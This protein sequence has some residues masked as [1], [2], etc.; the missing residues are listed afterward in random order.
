[1]VALP[2]PRPP[3]P[4]LRMIRVVFGG[5]PSSLAGILSA[6]PPPPMRRPGL[7]P[8]PK[9]A[10]LMHRSRRREARSSHTMAATNKGLARS[11]KSRT[12]GGATKGR[13]PSM[14]KEG[15][16]VWPTVR[17]AHYRRSR[18]MR[19][20]L[21]PLAIAALLI[22][23]LTSAAVAMDIM[24]GDKGR[25]HG[26]LPSGYIGAHPSNR[27]VHSCTWSAS[28]YCANWRTAQANGDSP[29]QARSPTANHCDSLC[30]AKCQATW[31][32]GGLPS[33]EAC[34]AKW[35]RLNANGTARQCEAAN[36]A[37][38]AGQPKLPGC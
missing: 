38:L 6:A 20:V 17:S 36:R 14:N 25:W 19:N 11:N 28:S 3:R 32:R 4:I 10:P 13:K 8:D 35:S 21:K 15:W 37:R 16:S 22:A 9:P 2:A 7:H 23:P 27:G 29:P 5:A 30:Q 34:Y 12:G 24:P 1:M 31:Q 18:K 33:V 26:Y